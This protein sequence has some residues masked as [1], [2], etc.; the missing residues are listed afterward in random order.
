MF[1]NNFQVGLEKV[2]RSKGIPL[3]DEETTAFNNL[4]E[5]NF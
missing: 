1:Q 2:F 5:Y 4:I 3:D